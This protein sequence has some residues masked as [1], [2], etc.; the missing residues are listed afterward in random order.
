[1]K[2]YLWSQKDILENET[3]LKSLFLKNYGRRIEEKKFRQ[4]YRCNPFGEPKAV[5]IK[6]NNCIVGFYGIIPQKIKKRSEGKNVS[7]KYAL[8]VSLMINERYRGISALSMIVRLIEKE[9]IGEHFEFLLGFP[10]ENSYAP[11]AKIFGWR[12]LKEA[13]FLKYNFENVKSRSK[14]KIEYNEN[15]KIGNKWS[16]PYD[17]VSFLEWKSICNK[18]ITVK[19]GGLKILF[20]ER[21][22]D[23][24][25]ILDVKTDS[26]NNILN[27]KIKETVHSMNKVGLV[28]T[29]FHAKKLGLSRK[30]GKRANNYTIRM[31]EKGGFLDK[32]NIRFSLLMSDVF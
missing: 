8:G 10:N 20:K 6:A 12:K 27:R 14:V 13:V 31:C 15:I 28:T 19:S 9:L 32:R 4:L 23:F 18:Y 7:E 26:G 2:V 29:S 17:E 5:V 1:M 25:D 3:R 21:E 30:N 16:P 22:D 11:L 24:I